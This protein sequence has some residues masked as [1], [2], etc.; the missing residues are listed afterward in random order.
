MYASWRSGGPLLAL[1]A[2]QI[3]QIHESTYVSR[4]AGFLAT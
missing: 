2:V 3:G 4:I 1:A